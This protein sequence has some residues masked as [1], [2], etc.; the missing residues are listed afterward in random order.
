MA[1]IAD[2]VTLEQ[3]LKLEAELGWFSLLAPMI[4]TMAR[5][6]KAVAHSISN[7]EITGL[8]GAT[9][10]DNTSG[11]HVQ[12][13]DVVAQD[14]IK[15]FAAASGLVSCMVSEE[16]GGII[17]IPKGYSVGEYVLAFDPLDG[18]SNINCNITV[19][20][21]WSI[22]HRVGIDDTA[23]ENVLQKGKTIQAAGYILYG[24]RTQFVYAANHGVHVFT[25][26]PIS[27][28]FILTQRNIRMPA[29]GKVYSANEGNTNSWNEGVKKYVQH[30]KDANR[31]GRCSGAMVADFHRILLNGGIFFYPNPKLR[32]L[33]EAV[34][35]AFIAKAAG[36]A[37]TD[38][39]GD[40]LNILPTD[41][42]Q[43]TPLIFGSSEDV[44]E[45]LDITR[46][47]KID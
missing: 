44:Q 47:S 35:A 23:V 33:Y 18:S 46:P 39:I 9:G 34:P 42:H 6:G 32:L 26:D 16:S 40:I 27:G 7:A 45:Y 30:L 37:A 1:H 19:G 11:D 41:I 28:D 22:R 10:H 21:I 25:L 43:K 36:G 3:H 14:T 5:A 8:I 38:G 2:L 4:Y 31:V 17:P 20:T 15:K 13:L 24:A 29:R 12:M